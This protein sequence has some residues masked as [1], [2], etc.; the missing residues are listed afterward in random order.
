MEGRGF[1]DGYD[2]RVRVKGEKCTC[3]GN[4]VNRCVEFHTEAKNQGELS[5]YFEE[6]ASHKSHVAS[7][8]PSS[9]VHPSCARKHTTGRRIAQQRNPQV[10]QPKKER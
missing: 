6:G 3:I 7:E 2:A 5:I 4:L 8:H 1:V 9:H 10:D